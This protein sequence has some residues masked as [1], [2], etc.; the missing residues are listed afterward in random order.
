MSA[1]VWT[2]YVFSRTSFVIAM[3]MYRS[4]CLLG[5]DCHRSC[6]GGYRSHWLGF[7]ISCA[8]CLMIKGGC[9][10]SIIIVAAFFLRSYFL[11]C[12]WYRSHSFFV[13]LY[14]YSGFL[15]LAANPSL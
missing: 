7:E 14:A 9:G 6:G 2:I 1:C 13:V 4:W 5:S 12:E 3:L 15:D 10:I 8:S 11:F